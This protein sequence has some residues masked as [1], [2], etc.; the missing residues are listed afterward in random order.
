MP[1][2][3]YD[4]KM[5]IIPLNCK[6]PPEI[7][8]YAWIALSDLQKVHSDKSDSVMIT[9]NGFPYNDDGIEI[10]LRGRFVTSPTVKYFNPYTV[11]IF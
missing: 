8:G 5:R 4:E 2:A 3:K 9:S 7:I 10:Q 6:E 1:Q 11:N